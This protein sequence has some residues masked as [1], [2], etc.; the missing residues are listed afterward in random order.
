MENKIK[1]WEDY[2]IQTMKIKLSKDPM[3]VAALALCL[4]AFFCWVILLS[5]KYFH[6][7]Y[8]DWDLAFF[9]QGMWNLIHGSGYVSVFDTNFF[10][11]HANLIACLVIPLYKVFPHPLT[12]VFL[13]V[14]SYVAAAFILYTLAKE[15]LGSRTALIFLCLYLLYVPNVMGIFYEFDFE[16]LAPAF[17]MLIYYF[18]VK[19]RWVGFLICA[20]ILILIKENL[21]LIILAFSIHGLFVKKDKVRW[22]VIPGILA[23][24]SF[25]LLVFVFIPYVSGKPIGE[26]NPYYIGQNYKDLGGSI[27]GVFYSFIFH[28]IKFLRYV[29]TPINLNFLLIILAPFICLP[30]ARPGILFLISP[31]LFQHLLSS[32]RT[33]QSVFYAYVLTIAPFFFLATIESLSSLYKRARRTFH[34]ILALLLLFNFIYFFL[35]LQEMGKRFMPE[36]VQSEEMTRDRWELFHMIPPDASVIA[37]FS[38]L[39]PLSQRKDLYAFYKIYDFRYQNGPGAFVLPVTVQYA[40]IDFDD[41]WLVH[42]MNGQPGV[43][44]RLNKFFIQYKWKVIKRYGKIMLYNR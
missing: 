24:V 38:F 8:Q 35:N 10:A 27:G 14:L 44:S 21:P 25:Y 3:D 29:M 15:K 39:T 18:Y 36:G 30:L 19:D 5:Y 33:E 2:F 41:P 17:L 20:V 16:S 13:K 4:F 37:S 12:L 42:R 11:N 26:E 43:R 31:I 32:F 1:A 7:G 40:L 22:A 23:L 9:A 28:P 6:F 34:I